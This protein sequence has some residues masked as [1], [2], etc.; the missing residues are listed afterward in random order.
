LWVAPHREEKTKTASADRKR[1]IVPRGPFLVN[2]QLCCH[3]VTRSVG[4]ELHFIREVQ[5]VL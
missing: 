5:P 2:S 1:R 4:S 3:G